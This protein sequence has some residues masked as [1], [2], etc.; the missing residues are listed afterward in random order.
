MYITPFFLC[1]SLIILIDIIL[2]WRFSFQFNLHVCTYW[3]LIVYIFK[4]Q[5]TQVTRSMLV[6]VQYCNGVNYLFVMIVGASSIENI[7]SFEQK[8]DTMK[9]WLTITLCV[10]FFVGF[11]DFR[12]VDSFYTSYLTSPA[13][14]FTTKQVSHV[15]NYNIVTVIK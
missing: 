9:E 6:R 4:I 11:R 8:P 10:S 2:I 14:N 13:V 5:L 12:P 7:Q 15:T 1:P 3:H